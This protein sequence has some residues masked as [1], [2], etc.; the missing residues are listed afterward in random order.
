MT[1]LARDSWQKLTFLMGSIFSSLP[2]SMTASRDASNY[3]TKSAISDTEM[4]ARGSLINE[5]KSDRPT[6][7]TAMVCQVCQGAF[8]DTTGCTSPLLLCDGRSVDFLEVR[9]F[10]ATRCGSDIANWGPGLAQ[11]HKS[12]SKLEHKWLLLLLL[13]EP[14]I[15]G[16]LRFTE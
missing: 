5:G 11:T 7:T 14:N 6:S 13:V 16:S 15:G 10:L 9:S 1:S 4:F 12:S 2:R 8:K 3:Y